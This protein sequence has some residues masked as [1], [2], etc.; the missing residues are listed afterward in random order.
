M[1]K[2]ML[3][4]IVAIGLCLFAL[5]IAGTIY[6]LPFGLA[7]ACLGVIIVALEERTWRPK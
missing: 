6:A 1:I 5:S 2:L 4:T 7:V 3:F